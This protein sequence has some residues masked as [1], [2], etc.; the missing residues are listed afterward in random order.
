MFLEYMEY[1]V[2]GGTIATGIFAVVAVGGVSG[3]IEGNANQLLIQLI[4]TV[5]TMAYAFV[6]TLIIGKFIDWTIGLRVSEKEE[7]EGLDTHVHE[8]SGYRL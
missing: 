7:I 4:A 8:E 5:S 3:L 2:F 1:R 6:I